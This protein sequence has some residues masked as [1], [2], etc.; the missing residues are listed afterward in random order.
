MKK[1]ALVTSTEDGGFILETTD[2]RLKFDSMA[3]LLSFCSKQ[4]LEAKFAK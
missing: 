1:E 3:P 4:N 2:S